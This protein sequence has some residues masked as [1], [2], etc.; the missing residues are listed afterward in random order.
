MTPRMYP[1]KK[2]NFSN[3]KTL[4]TLTIY[5]Q[6]LTKIKMFCDSLSQKTKHTTVVLK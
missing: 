6:F 1:I 4:A 5:R 2:N 3:T